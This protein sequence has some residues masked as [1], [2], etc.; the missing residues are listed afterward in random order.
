LIL[1]AAARSRIS[2]AE[3]GRFGEIG[4][5]HHDDDGTL[6]ELADDRRLG[7][8]RAHGG[9]LLTRLVTGVLPG[10]PREARFLRAELDDLR[11]LLLG[12]IAQT[13]VQDRQL[14]LQIGSEKN[15]GR[16][17]GR[18]VDGRL[19]IREHRGGQTVTELG[20][21]I[22]RSERSRQA[23]P[24][25][26]VFV[27]ATGTAENGHASGATIT[28]GRRDERGG[29]A[30]RRGPIGLDELAITLDERLIETRVGRDR[31]EVETSLVAQPAPVDR[32][33]VDTLVSQQL[34][35]ARLDRDATTDRARGAGALD[36]LEIPR[37]SLE[38]IRLSRERPD[39]ADLH[40]VARE[41]AAERL[42]R[43]R[44]HLCVVAAR[45]E[46]NERV[47]RHFVGEPR[48][49][50]AQDAPLTI[51]QDDV[52]D[53]NR[54]LVVALLLDEAALT[55]TVAERLVL[56]RALTTL[57]A[58]RTI[59]GMVRQQQFENALVRTLHLRCVGA[60]HLTVGHRCHAR[61]HHHRSTRTFDFDETLPAH[62]DRAHAR[63]VA[64]AR[65][66]VTAAIGGGDY[67]FALASGNRTT[68]DRNRDGVGIDRRLVLV[69]RHVRLGGGHDTDPETGMRV[70]LVTR[71]SNSL[72]NN[73]RA[74]WT[75]A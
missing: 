50:I 39:R 1:P 35:A 42:V 26:S 61:H 10:V 16:G 12:C 14:F 11:A 36:L 53:R 18:F 64:E 3:L 43:E 9:D 21:D 60:H 34:I 46:V 15:D 59:E 55:R 31:L 23:R 30:Q 72:R 47:A 68:V 37:A 62:A 32:I 41:I 57:V 25:V 28:E 71:A 5:S 27:G 29:G 20:V 52:A 58:H 8:S 49:A 22:R 38:S 45:C 56:E 74:E 73:V 7:E 63:V 17:I 54:L 40:R 69:A 51:E 4:A 19:R 44:E 66:V 33:A 70:R 2:T 48:A 65:D 13:Q 6:A 75:G 67:E 24:R